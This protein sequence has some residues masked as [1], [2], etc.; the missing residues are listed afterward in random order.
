[1]AGRARASVAAFGIYK[2]LLYGGMKYF[3]RLRQVNTNL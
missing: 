2:I 1:M 3:R